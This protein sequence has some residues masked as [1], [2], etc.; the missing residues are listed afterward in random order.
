MAM[1]KIILSNKIQLHYFRLVA[2]ILR[3][4]SPELSKQDI[5]KWHPKLLWYLLVAVT[6]CHSFNYHITAGS[7]R[8]NFYY[9]VFLHSQPIWQFGILNFSSRKQICFFSFNCSHF[10]PLPF[11]YLQAYPAGIKRLIQFIAKDFSNFTAP[12]LPSATAYRLLP[13]T[14]PYPTLPLICANSRNKTPFA[15]TDV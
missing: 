4:T 11:F 5:S 15:Q 10:H 13:A 8:P 7:T 12:P 2:S 9:S 14:T 1:H 6:K 3:G